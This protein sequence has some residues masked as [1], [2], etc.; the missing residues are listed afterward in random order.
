MYIHGEFSLL[1][2]GWRQYTMNEITLNETDRIYVDKIDFLTA[3]TPFFHVDRI[4]KSNVFIYVTSG[5]IYVSEEGIDYEI[6]PGDMI[7]LKQGTHQYGTKLIAAGTSWIYAHFYIGEIVKNEVLDFPL[8][9]DSSSIILPK[10]VHNLVQTDFLQRLKQLIRLSESNKTLCKN[11]VSSSFQS[12]LLDLY[13]HDKP[14]L[15]KDLSDQILEYLQCRISDTL[16][17]KE[18]E[19][20]FHLTYKYLTRT[21]SEKNGMGILQFHTRLKMQA[22]AKELR[23]TNKNISSIVTEFG[24]NDAL[25]FSKCFRKQ[26]GISPSE[27]RKNQIFDAFFC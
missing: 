5:C 15:Q 18:I 17:G 9:L 21:F 1:G 7:L 6:A 10:M 20:D 4:A 11:R 25:Y 8:A 3:N 26:F 27:Y 2:E 24:F 22:A 13:E 23:S 16:S 14:D 19:Q 12:I